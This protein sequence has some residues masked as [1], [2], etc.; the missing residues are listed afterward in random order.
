MK[1]DLK[2]HHYPAKRVSIGPRQ[3]PKPAA[4]PAGPSVSP[5]ATITPAEAD[6]PA[7]DATARQTATER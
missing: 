7:S 2:P 3:L 1:E 6:L 4:E 5:P